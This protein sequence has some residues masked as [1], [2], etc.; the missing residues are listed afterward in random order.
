[1][2]R[3]I[4]PVSDVASIL[5]TQDEGDQRYLPITYSPP[6]VDL[7][8][9]YT[10]VQSDARYEPIDTMYTKAE[11]DAKYL[12]QVLADA[13]YSLTSHN[14]DTSYSLLTHNH[15]A[16]YSPTAHNHDAAYF[17]VAGDT[18]YGGGVMIRDGGGLSLANTAFTISAG[19]KYSDA[20]GLGCI[21]NGAQTGTY[22]DTNGTPAVK[23]ALSIFPGAENL[24]GEWLLNN[25]SARQA[26]IGLEGDY[27]NWRV[28][29]NIGTPGN[30]LTIRLTDGYV[31]IPGGLG[32]S[33]T[34][35]NTGGLQFNGSVGN[36][37]STANIQLSP[38]AGYVH[39]SG[40]LNCFI[41]H[42]S[43]RWN[44]V[45]TYWIKGEQLQAGGDAGQNV[46]MNYHQ[47]RKG[48]GGHIQVAGAGNFEPEQDNFCILGGNV[49]R[50]QSVWSNNG[51]INTSHAVSKKNFTPLDPAACVE[52]V[53][54]TDWLSF[55]YLPPPPPPPEEGQTPKE[56]LAVLDSYLAEA[57]KTYVS[58]KQNGYVLGH[59]THK[60][61]DLFGLTDRQSASASS[62][63]GILACAL[64]DALLKVRDLNARVTALEEP[65]P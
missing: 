13:R 28:Y 14:H 62:D 26:Y 53:L 4:V 18:I 60:T 7:S 29:S 38:A 40:D 3:Q 42:P 21:V 49:N 33:G 41:G 58:R 17:N 37:A 23:G 54:G 9:Y 55:E 15:D 46:L 19:W 34:L 1:M 2:P 50:W 8:L 35:T 12:T 30:R 52:A 57:A 25:A 24:A 56:R 64:Q 20:V 16:A 32:V 10:K 43:L 5:L 44:A 45:Y 65:Q 61:H 63:L 36:I 59:E 31:S 27:V 47:I 6:P 48:G 39:P 22:F 11:S 51:S